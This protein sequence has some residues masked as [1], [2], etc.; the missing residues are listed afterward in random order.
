MQLKPDGT[1]AANIPKSTS[2]PPDSHV[3][4][5]SWLENDTF[6]IIYTPTEGDAIAS[7]SRLF[8]RPEGCFLNIANPDGIEASLDQWGPS[9]EVDIITCSDG[10]Q[11]LGEYSMNG[12]CLCHCRPTTNGMFV[13]YTCIF[14]S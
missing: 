7:Y 12:P 11:I 14:H 13:L 5:I 8:R 6:F 9:E 2:I 4:G 3:S 10:E 1:V